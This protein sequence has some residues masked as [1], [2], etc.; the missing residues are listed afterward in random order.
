MKEHLMIPT[1][2]HVVMVKS[3]MLACAV[4]AGIVNQLMEIDNE[5][6]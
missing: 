5:S 4:I 1:I 6:Y 2:V 3:L